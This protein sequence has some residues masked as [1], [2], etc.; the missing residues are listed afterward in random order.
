MLYLDYILFIIVITL[1]IIF[2][3]KFF[4]GKSKEGFGDND[5]PFTHKGRAFLAETKKKA[6][7]IKSARYGSGLSLAKSPMPGIDGKWFRST[8]VKP[9][10][11]RLLANNTKTIVVSS[12]IFEKD[13]A[14]DENKVLVVKFS[15]G[16][17][18]ASD[19]RKHEKVSIY[20]NMEALSDGWIWKDGDVM[21]LKF[22]NGAPDT[23]WMIMVKNMYKVAD[24]FAYMVIR[25]PYK[26]LDNLVEMGIELMQNYKELLKPL[27]DFID[28]MQ[29]MARNMIK[30]G[31]AWVK[32]GYKRGRQIMKNLPKFIKKQLD[33]IIQIIQDMITNIFE[34]IEPLIEIL[35]III[36]TIIDIP[37]IIFKIIT[38]LVTML[39]NIV[40]MLIKLPQSLLAMIIS[41]QEIGLSMMEKTPTIPFLDLFLQ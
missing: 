23:F 5:K 22:V 4:K 27:F 2:M 25:M 13:P 12:A 17:T 20:K 8:D 37:N 26:F 1:F 6:S 33:R 16:T 19:A 24:L 36:D 34:L 29:C 9:I 28:Q 38:Q 30:Y 3:N 14:P 7:V 32:W 15:D 10:L 40:I 31:F 21:S 41:F 39:S 11:D 35:A 18:L